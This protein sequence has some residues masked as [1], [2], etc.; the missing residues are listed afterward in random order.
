MC[1]LKSKHSYMSP[2]LWSA[3]LSRT[4]GH[5]HIYIH[6]QLEMHI[7]HRYNAMCIWRIYVFPPETVSVASKRSAIESRFHKSEHSFLHSF[8]ALYSAYIQSDPDIILVVPSIIFS[9]FCCKKIFLWSEYIF[10]CHLITIEKYFIIFHSLI[11]FY[12]YYIKITK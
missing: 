2:G 6:T 10:I 9:S 11:F 4:R 7:K 8:R 5:A 3:A 1:I 12:C